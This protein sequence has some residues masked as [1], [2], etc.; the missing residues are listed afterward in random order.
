MKSKNKLKKSWTFSKVPKPLPKVVD[1][2]SHFE[3]N[4]GTPLSNKRSHL[5]PF[6]H[7]LRRGPKVL[8][9][10]LQTVGTLQPRITSGPWLY[11][12][13]ICIITG[14]LTPFE[15]FASSMDVSDARIQSLLVIFFL[16]FYLYNFYI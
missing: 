8:F 13:C 6:A 11:I 7:T 1:S 9:P 12:F 4:F 14:K 5:F 16:N 10:T 2:R 15:N 3:I